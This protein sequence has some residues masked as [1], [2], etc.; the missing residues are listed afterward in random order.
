M[1]D[2]GESSAGI[3]AR[4]HR[5]FPFF[6]QAQRTGCSN[7]VEAAEAH[8]VLIGVKSL[9]SMFRGQVIVETDC[10]MLVT[11]LLSDK[12]I[13]SEAFPFIWDT[14]D[15]LKAFAAFRVN[16]VKRDQNKIAHKLATH[17]RLNGDH[18][19][20]AS[21]PEGIRTDVLNEFRQFS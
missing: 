6:S 14:K 12:V 21:V 2:T 8:A 3:I 7:S 5:G 4:D 20:L 9:S 18:F 13:R 17:A 11:E 15:N 16:W 19:W 1:S 10:A